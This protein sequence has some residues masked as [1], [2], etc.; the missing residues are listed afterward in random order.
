VRDEGPTS[1][2][3]LA[4]GALT[5]AH[6]YVMQF[7][8]HAQTIATGV[9]LFARRPGPSEPTEWN[10]RLAQECLPHPHLL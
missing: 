8:V 6:C 9:W 1:T 10:S 3:T 2:G 4:C 7:K 5:H